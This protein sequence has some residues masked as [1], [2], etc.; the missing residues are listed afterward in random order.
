MEHEITREE[1]LSRLGDTS[2]TLLNVLPA[3]TFRD[4]RIPGSLN[5]PLSEVTRTAPALLPD[6][7]REI[8]VYCASF[9]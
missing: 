1:I 6:R 7:A 9:T 4:G 3:E 8:A 5:L 2:F